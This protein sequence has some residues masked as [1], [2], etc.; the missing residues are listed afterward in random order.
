VTGDLRYERIIAAAPEVVFDAFTSAGGQTAFYATD[1]PGWVV[2]SESDV[3]VGGAWTI[4]FGPSPQRLYRHHHVFE[5]IERPRRIVLDT[6][7]TRLDGTTLRFRTEFAFVEH[8]RG[9]SMTMLQRGIPTAELREEH[10]RGVPDAF[11]RLE[12]YLRDESA[13]GGLGR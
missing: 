9:T 2:H 5:V 6:T 12:R 11:D 13:A 7:E 10:A 4:A 8:E 1:E 3:R